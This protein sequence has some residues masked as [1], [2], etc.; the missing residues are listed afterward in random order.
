MVFLQPQHLRRRIAG[1]DF[2]ACLFNESAPSADSVGEFS[3]LLCGG[4]VTP[5]LH[6]IENLPIPADG[7]EAVL[8]TGNSDSL[9]FSS[10]LLRNEGKAVPQGIKPP[11]RELLPCAVRQA[12][13]IML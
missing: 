11:G 5:E 2:V 7:N 1:L 8:L 12:Y 3:A 4:C 10:D 9:D 6:G 13:E